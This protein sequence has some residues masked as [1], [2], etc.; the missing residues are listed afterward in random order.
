M[1]VDVPLW[2]AGQF[3]LQ[4]CIKHGGRNQDVRIY[5]Q[6]K[7]KHLKIQFKYINYRRRV[8]IY[9]FLNCRANLKVVIL[10]ESSINIQILVKQKGERQ[11]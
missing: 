1:R 5:N 4:T 10:V 7:C 8:M 11:C 2:L 6:Y 9:Q 3:L